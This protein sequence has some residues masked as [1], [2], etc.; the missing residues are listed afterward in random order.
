[1]FHWCL[2][3]HLHLVHGAASLHF[4]FGMLLQRLWC[5]LRLARANPSVV[6]APCC[7]PG[8]SSSSVPFPA[9]PQPWM[10]EAFLCDSLV[11]CLSLIPG[12]SNPGNRG[13]VLVHMGEPF[14]SAVAVDFRLVPKHNQWLLLLFIIMRKMHNNNHINTIRM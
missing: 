7:V 6:L 11:D 9:A 4:T 14:H 13:M 5:I 8:A 1:M 3:F 2:Q 10:G 12:A